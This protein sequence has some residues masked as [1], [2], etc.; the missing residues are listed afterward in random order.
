MARHGRGTVYAGI[1]HV[2]R[3]SAG[4]VEMFRDDFDFTD[5]CRRL[6]RTIN[7]YSWTCHFFCL[8]TTH[9]HLLLEVEEDALQPGMHELNGEYAQEFNRRWGRAGHLRGGPY[10]AKL[11][12]TD[13]H[14]FEVVRYIARNPVEAGMCERPADWTW[15]SYRGC[16]GYDDD[17][18]PFVTNDFV[19]SSFHEDRTRA[20]RLLRAF[21][22]LE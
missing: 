14:L 13:E 22:E 9:Y 11:V 20:I 3:R 19:L 15:S 10:G 8:M 1:Y 2:T 7:R 4:P 21:V 17:G 16:A 12:S 18:F 5:F 6:L